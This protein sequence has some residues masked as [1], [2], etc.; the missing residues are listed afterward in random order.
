MGS[1]PYPQHLTLLLSAVRMKIGKELSTCNPNCF[2]SAC[3]ITDLQAPVSAKLLIIIGFC[4][5]PV[6]GLFFVNCKSIYGL[7]C[8]RSRFFILTLYIEGTLVCFLLVLL[9]HFFLMRLES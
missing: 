4:D 5:C 1:Y 3:D 8:D 9:L 2:A 7:S 6:L